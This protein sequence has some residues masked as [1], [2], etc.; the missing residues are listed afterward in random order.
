MIFLRT[1]PATAIEN[2]SS[3][4]VSTECTFFTSY[5]SRDIPSTCSTWSVARSLITSITKHTLIPLEVPEAHSYGSLQAGA[6]RRGCSGPRAGAARG[7]LSTA[8]PWP[9]RGVAPTYCIAVQQARECQDRM[10]CRQ[11]RPRP[12][13]TTSSS[14]RLPTMERACR[15][16]R[17]M[18]CPPRRSR[19]SRR[20]TRQQSST[21]SR[22]TA[23]SR[24]RAT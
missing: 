11:G 10:V 3:T 20:S 14:T 9:G 12:P 2:R 18:C 24:T 15:K 1:F 19:S 5:D 13:T 4:I 23:T 22:E 21:Y 6:W 8:A 16:P 7:S 17:P